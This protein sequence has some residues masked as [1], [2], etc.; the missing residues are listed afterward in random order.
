MYD[1]PVSAERPRPEILAPAGDPLCLRAAIAA[2]ADAVYLGMAR[3]NARGRA[4]R[5]RG[6]DLAAC[7]RAAHDR[8]V[9]V[10]VT[11]NTLLRDDELPAGLDLAAEALSAGADAAIVQ[12]PGFAALLAERLPGLALHGSTQMTLH[13]P[14]QAAEAVKRLGLRR[15]IVARECSLDEVRGIVEALRPLGAGVEVFVHGALCLAYSGQCLMSNFA[16]RRSANRGICAQNCRFDYVA[17]ERFQGFPPSGEGRVAEA[18]VPPRF[19]RRAASQLLSLKDLSAIAS[20]AA[21]ADA[22]VAGFK[23]EGRLKGPEYVAQ[24]TRLYR[25]AVDAWAEGRPFA[26]EEARREAS[27]VFTRGFTNGYLEGTRDSSMRGDKRWLEGEPD[28][29]VLW[30][31]RKKGVL[32]LEPRSG[33]AIRPGQ[34]YRYAHDRYLGGFRVLS[35][36]DERSRDGAPGAGAVSVRVR[37][38]AEARGRR[39]RRGATGRRRP[40]P[41][42][43]VGLACYLNDD[44][45]LARRVSA[46]VAEVEIPRDAGAVGLRLV[47]SGRAGEPLRLRAES[48]DGR[49]EEA[50]SRQT[51][52]RAKS[53]AL[54]GSALAAHLGRLGGTDYRLAGID[55]SALEPGLFLPLSALNALRRELVAALDRAVRVPARGEGARASLLAGLDFA[56]REPRRTRTRLSACVGSEAALGAAVSAGVECAYLE[57]AWALDLAAAPASLWF[58][59]PPIVHDEAFDRDAVAAIR[60]RFPDAGILAGHLG[61]VRLARDAGLRA[62]ADLYLNA[63]NGRAVEWLGD[64]GASRVTVS[65][66]LEAREVARLADLARA[67]IEIEVVVGGSVPSM[68]TRQA[69]GLR[70]G[71]AFLATSEHGYVYRLAAAPW[72]GTA[73]YEARE[74]VGPDALAEVYGRADW[75]RLDLARS[76]EAAVYEIARA[77]RNVLDALGDSAPGSAEV[78]EA[79]A[80]ARAVH[81]RHAPWGAFSGHLARGSRRL[82]AEGPSS[83]ASSGGTRR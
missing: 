45:E 68:L 73:I 44:P 59:L 39:H 46:L 36:V 12:D 52:A 13:Q 3:F 27:R 56:G 81:S 4:E 50:R 83:G 60:S 77:Y 64:A 14:A 72:G 10:Y 7:V 69:F 34:G 70:E 8:G 17:G 51:L 78:E 40:P 55:A 29:T 74:L 38:G 25:A 41:P 6:V 42:L 24:T 62:A 28:A 71:E 82:D 16:G 48:E 65:L 37:F 80:E 1:G 76:R 20:V 67:S 32:A 26:D 57:G 18:P 63:S 9:K 79:V 30:A 15:A 58:R 54:D 53:R 2:G 43:P 47:A 33:H 35:V 66:E 49:A 61:Q 5:F 19:D 31:D 22:G 75:V 21:L 23:I 11:L